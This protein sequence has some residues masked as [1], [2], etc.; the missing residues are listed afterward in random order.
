MERR[1]EDESI[2][3]N[4]RSIGLLSTCI[5]LQYG[6]GSIGLLSALLTGAGVLFHVVQSANCPIPP[7][8]SSKITLLAK[9]RFTCVSIAVING[10]RFQNDS[11][12]HLRYTLPN[13]KLVLNLV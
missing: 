8:L 3:L 1:R 10:P 9:L 2:S 4:G 12:Q 6:L 5:L 11:P 7:F 13:L